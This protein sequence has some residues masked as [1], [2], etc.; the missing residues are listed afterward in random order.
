MDFYTAVSQLYDHIFPFSPAQLQFVL[1][2]IQHPETARVLEV[3]C[4]TGSLTAALTESCGKVTGI[5]L[6]EAMI[7]KAEEKQI[8]SS[9]KAE[10]VMLN[11]KEL[12]QTFPGQFFDAV[13]S[14]GNTLVHLADPDEILNVLKQIKQLLEPGGTLMLQIINYDRILDHGITKLPTIEN[15]KIRFERRYALTSSHHI[16]FSSRLTEKSSGRTGDQEVLLYPLR[17]TDLADMLPAAGF[18][19]AAWYGGFDFSPL[20]ED[21]VP[22]IVSAKAE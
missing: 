22:L 21:S 14:F 8:G 19:D 16:R 5:D 20:K 13:L 17:K 1:E 7:R 3:G 11:M 12:R 2:H 10:Y 18:V 9:R 15:E 6:S 4:G